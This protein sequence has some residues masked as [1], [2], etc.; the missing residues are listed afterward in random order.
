MATLT[1]INAQGNE[2]PT[3]S[4]AGDV[5]VTRL[6]LW[7]AA[8]NAV[9]NE[10]PLT[11]SVEKARATLRRIVS[12]SDLGNIGNSERSPTVRLSTSWIPFCGADDFLA[13]VK[14]I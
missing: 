9:E 4:K 8:T 10:R 12:D 2:R 3:V 7:T 5:V 13:P 6:K 11:T 14:S 1:N